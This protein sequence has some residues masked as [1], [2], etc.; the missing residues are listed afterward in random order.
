[1]GNSNC[2]K[3]KR[4]FR[5]SSFFLFA[6]YF[7]IGSLL[8][9]V[10]KTNVVEA[11]SV[12]VSESENY[13]IEYS[14]GDSASG[15]SE[16]NENLLFN[17]S[18]WDK[19]QFICGNGVIEGDE[20]C[21]V[22]FPEGASCESYGDYNDGNLKCEECRIV[23]SDCIVIGDVDVAIGDDNIETIITKVVD[24]VV[25]FVKDVINSET[26]NIKAVDSYLKDDWVMI[27][28][29]ASVTILTSVL[30]AVSFLGVTDFWGI[31][32][33]VFSNILSLFGIW[34]RGSY[35]GF[36][37][38]SETYEPVSLA[39]I[40][41]FNDEGKLIESVVTD[42]YGMYSLRKISQVKE[43]KVYKQGFKFP[44]T[45][46]SKRVDSLGRKIYLGEKIKKI[47]EIQE[48]FIP[49]DPIDK[50]K[51]FK[52]WVRRRL[53]RLGGVLNVISNVAYI[54]ATL[55]VLHRV[56]NDFSFINVAILVWYLWVFIV[57]LWYRCNGGNKY[58]KIYFGKEKIK[59]R[60]MVVA[61]DESFDE[62]KGVYITDDSAV[63]RL[64]VPKGLYK[65]SVLDEKGYG[66]SNDVLEIK[67]RRS[68]TIIN[69]NIY[70]K[71]S[72]N[73]KK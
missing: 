42:I 27:V 26:I 19:L 28:N 44:S 61:R 41:C 7:G 11:G 51:N 58:G 15:H 67:G 12:G 32:R 16:G 36:V 30:S 10:L 37:Y 53:F 38:N 49:I 9:I 50:N 8:L 34:V 62:I 20:Q 4:V 69:K 13:S 59:E 47:D 31:S 3:N 63:Y 25:T 54:F 17:G 29:V 14:I 73:D 22:I 35:V 46:F 65:L 60:S 40:R 18:N 6:L 71:S 2:I 23:T 64:I 39:I 72:Q 68:P 45:V 43:V 66:V 5:K 55:I 21:D 56:F 1:M 57:Y 33:L 52:F 70:I 24:D 48:A